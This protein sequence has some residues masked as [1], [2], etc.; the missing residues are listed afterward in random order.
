[1]GAVKKADSARVERM[2]VMG[3]CACATLGIP[4]YH[5]V[6][7]H[8][9][10]SGHRQL[11]DWYTIPLCKGHHQGYFTESQRIR[12]RDDERV[13]IGTG[14][15]PFNEKF[16]TER[17][18]WEKIQFVLDLSRDWPGSKIVP[19]RLP[20]EALQPALLTDRIQPIRRPVLRLRKA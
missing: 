15:K 20:K 3:C 2:L 6:E 13:S 14:R 1:M 12:L 8:H 5:Q 9:I 19:R 10:L 17:E 7:A 18:L 4:N 16:G 11:G